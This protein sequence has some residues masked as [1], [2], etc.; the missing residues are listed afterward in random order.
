MSLASEYLRLSEQF[1]LKSLAACG[2]SK[3]KETG[4][5]VLMIQLDQFLGLKN[6]VTFFA[7]SNNMIYVSTHVSIYLYIL[8]LI[9]NSVLL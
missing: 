4:M 8:Y 2:L 7:F 1:S 6:K 3:I 9:Q 5:K